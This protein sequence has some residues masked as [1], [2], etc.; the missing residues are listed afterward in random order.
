MICFLLGTDR[1]IYYMISKGG[2]EALLQTLVDT[3]RS[4]SPDWDILLPLFRLLAKVGL[5]E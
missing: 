2:S 3:A 4:A 1:R 5:R